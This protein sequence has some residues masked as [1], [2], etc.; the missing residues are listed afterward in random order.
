MPHLCYKALAELPAAKKQVFGQGMQTAH[1]EPNT[2]AAAGR[3]LPAWL[4]GADVACSS[5]G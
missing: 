1:L 5:Q 4:W 3:E 2:A